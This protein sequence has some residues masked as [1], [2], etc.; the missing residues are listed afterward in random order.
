MQYLVPTCTKIVCY[1]LKLKFNQ[2]A[3]IFSGSTAPLGKTRAGSGYEHTG[4][5]VSAGEGLPSGVVALVR[6]IE[7]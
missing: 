2:T 7:P 6:G 1:Y 4:S 5:A 3:C